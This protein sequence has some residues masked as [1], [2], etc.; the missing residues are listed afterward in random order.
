MNQSR[1]L[2]QLALDTVDLPGARAL[3][4]TVRDLIDI[5]EIGTP[6]IIREGLR[7]VT[8][9]DRAYP[10]LVVLADL[11]IMD[12]GEYEAALAF[13]AGADIVT[14][15]AVAYDATIRGAVCAAK[16]FDTKV[17]A[18]LMAVNMIVDRVETLEAM[19]VDFVC[20]HTATDTLG[21]G[22]DGTAGLRSLRTKPRRAGVAVAGGLT[23]DGLTA[24][25][26]HRPDI[27]IVGS[28]ITRHSSPVEATRTIRT[29]LEEAGL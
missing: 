20:V 27:V 15:L 16:S 11:K 3:L 29:R 13:D 19:G 5:V 14:T 9:I 10:E 1:T 18:D 24:L 8:E 7:A 25:T 26:P 17:M 2:I 23:P 21:E 4:D 6:L 22:H 28:Y 12:A